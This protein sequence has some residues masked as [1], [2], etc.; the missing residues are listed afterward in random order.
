MP[1]PD[2]DRAIFP[3]D[4]EHP[5]AAFAQP[6][7]LNLG[8]CTMTWRFLLDLNIEDSALVE[9]A[10]ACKAGRVRA[11]GE[12]EKSSLYESASSPSA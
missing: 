7:V 1:G 6:K 9:V 11:L 5:R 10:E 8:L 2:R 3:D 4:L 12:H